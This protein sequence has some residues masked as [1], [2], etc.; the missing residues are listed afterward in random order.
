MPVQES[1]TRSNPAL[2]HLMKSIELWIAIYAAIVSTVLLLLRLR[3]SYNADG[4]IKIETYLHPPTGDMKSYLSF[5]IRNVGGAPVKITR[6]DLNSPGPVAIP[7]DEELILA[8][9]SLPHQ[10]DAKDSANW[11]VDADALKALI[12][13]NGWQYQVRGLA[14]VGTGK[15]IWESIHSYTSLT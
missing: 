5:K 11:A 9:P 12:R 4:R 15:Q 10:I 3:E 8:G 1:E 14:C 2:D 7:L 13:K 6:L